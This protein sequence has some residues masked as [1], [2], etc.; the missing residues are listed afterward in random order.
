M[1][2]LFSDASMC[3]LLQERD[4]D[5]ILYSQ[6]DRSAGGMM[7][8]RGIEMDF[9]QPGMMNLPRGGMDLSREF[10]P[11][12]ALD[13]GVRGFDF[14]GAPGLLG[15]AGMGGD[16][17]L[18]FGTG[19]GS[20]LV[21]PNAAAQSDIAPVILDQLGIE[22]PITNHVFVANV[23]SNV[24]FVYCRL[25]C[26]SLLLSSDDRHFNL[27]CFSFILDCSFIACNMTEGAIGVFWCGL[28]CVL[29]VI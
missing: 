26:F 5:R 3:V 24:H 8:E 23:S 13:I 28:E 10:D 22:G 19:F 2:T 1:F 27:F 4:H 25:N 12:N 20:G 6:A 14:R 15:A 21:Q 18:G 11:H 9:G 17:S 29:F 7:D 16:P